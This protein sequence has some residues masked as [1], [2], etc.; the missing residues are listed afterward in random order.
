MKCRPAGV[1]LNCRD[2]LQDII[3]GHRRLAEPLDI[4]SG[5]LDTKRVGLTQTKY[6]R[7]NV[8]DG[9]DPPNLKRV[10]HFRTEHLVSN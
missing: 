8:D 6:L 1:I 7:A 10:L 4:F 3:G 2:F 9:H 5:I